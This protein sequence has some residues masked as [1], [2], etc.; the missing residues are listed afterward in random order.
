MKLKINNLAI[1]KT[2]AMLF[3]SLSVQSPVPEML[4]DRVVLHNL[5]DDG[6]P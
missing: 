4:E 2:S 1:S 5:Q 6:F 3:L